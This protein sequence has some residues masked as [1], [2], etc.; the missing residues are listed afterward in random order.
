MNTIR[1]LIDASLSY[2]YKRSNVL[3]TAESRALQQLTTENGRLAIVA[4]DQRGSLVSMRERAGLPATTE[5]LRAIKSDIA[6]AL[7]PGA[8]ALLLDPEF[9]LP[10]LLD[11]RVVPRDT[12]VLVAVERS[13][14]RREN[15]LRVAELVLEPAPA[16][17]RRLGGTAAKLLVYVRPDREDADGQNG[18][19]VAGLVEACAGADLLL[20]VEVLSYRL[21]D[22]E[23]TQYERRKA[24]LG[25]EAALLVESCGAKVL[26]LESPGSEA[27]CARLTDA[28]TVPWAV[29]SAG[30]DHETFTTM[31]QEAIAGGASGFIAGRSLWKEAAL[32]PAPERRSFLLGEGRRR[33]DELNVLLR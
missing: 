20:I 11:D 26:K 17:V 23:P 19:L 12:G 25:L 27:A 16:E 2:G 32:L 22:E 5:E 3:T 13:G 24:D 8:S 15:G 21:E 1:G 33:L 10:A 29:L 28:L 30:V 9:A 4:N 14:G 18:R 6:E 31:L 7:G